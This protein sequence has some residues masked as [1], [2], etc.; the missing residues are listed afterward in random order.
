MCIS[1]AKASTFQGRFILNLQAD[2]IHFTCTFSIELAFWLSSLLSLNDSRKNEL[3]LMRT[4]FRTPS[5][6]TSVLSWPFSLTLREEMQCL[7]P[8]KMEIYKQKQKLSFTFLPELHL[9][10]SFSQKQSFSVICHW[11]QIKTVYYSVICCI[12]NKLHC[13]TSCIA[14]RTR[15][16]AD[17]IS[18]KWSNWLFCGDAFSIDNAGG[19]RNRLEVCPSHAAHPT[20]WRREGGKVSCW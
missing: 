8:K 3:P 19:S 13:N 14:Y 16:T 5:S 6:S 12:A 20:Q 11:F 2:K 9:N 10:D 15:V 17:K 1:V 18:I 4:V 7:P